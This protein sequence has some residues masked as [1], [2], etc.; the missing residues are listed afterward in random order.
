MTDDVI[1]TAETVGGTLS[2]DPQR[3]QRST[4][5]MILPRIERSRAIAA[6]ILLLFGAIAAALFNPFGVPVEIELA[7]PVALAGWV[8]GL[9]CVQWYLR[10][11]AARHPQSRRD[12]Q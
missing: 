5:A 12:Q 6:L 3:T 10:Q 11:Q 2:D 9:P 4:D 8:G 7:M 1:T